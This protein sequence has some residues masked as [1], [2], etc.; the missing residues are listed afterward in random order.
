MVKTRKQWIDIVRLLAMLL[1]I[2]GH[3]VEYK[4]KAYII[5]YSFHMPLFFMITALTFKPATD[6][7]EFKRHLIK[8]LKGIYLPCLI[9][10]FLRYL[11]GIFYDH[12][13]LISYSGD[14][15]YRLFW[16]NSYSSEVLY[17]GMPWFLIC[18]FWSKII[19]DFLCVTFKD[20]ANL[21]AIILAFSG[22]ILGRLQIFLPQSLD[23]ALVCL[24]FF[25]AIAIYKEKENYFIKYRY[26]IYLLALASLS[27]FVYRNALLELGTRGYP[28][29]GIS[30]I[31]SIVICLAILLL[32][33][34][35]CANKCNFLAFIGSQTLYIYIVH[36]LDYT[37]SFIWTWINKTS[38]QAV[39]HFM[40]ILIFS[41]C[42]IYIRKWYFENKAG[43]EEVKNA[44]S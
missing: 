40:M 36:C 28:L 16:A 3:I 32:F 9:V 39:V 8:N 19:Y 2:I 29:K 41:L 15:L 13:D 23:I 30:I 7:E 42:L 26:L 6:F 11:Y 44:E 5:I 31:L 21:F 25:V 38:L 22:F 17:L 4:S 35:I 14:M 34:N 37:Y 20:K 33:K 27:I 12:Y 24:S 10:I 1:V 43:Q 18:L